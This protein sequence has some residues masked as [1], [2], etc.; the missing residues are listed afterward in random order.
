LYSQ[1]SSFEE[2]VTFVRTLKP[3]T[4]HP[5]TQ[6]SK[7]DFNA[8]LDGAGLK[9]QYCPSSSYSSFNSDGCAD[10]TNVEHITHNQSDESQV[11]THDREGAIDSVA[12]PTSRGMKRKST[13]EDIDLLMKNIKQ[14]QSWW[15]KRP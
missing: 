3:R 14:S 7:S 4:I 10:E 1:H 12:T 11:M 13:C 6:L 8:L 5:L 15:Q 2:L 9:G